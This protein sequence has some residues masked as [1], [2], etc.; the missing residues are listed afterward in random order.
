[1]KNKRTLLLIALCA[2]MA[3]TAAAREDASASTAIPGK[4]QQIHWFT[5]ARATETENDLRPVEGLSRRA[6]TTTAGWHAGASAFPDAETCSWH[7]DLISIGHKSQ[8]ATTLI[9]EQ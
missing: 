9:R 5:A 3:A 2:G 7:M 4:R 1:M 8:P 6:W